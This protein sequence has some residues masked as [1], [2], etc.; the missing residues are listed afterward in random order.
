MG[1]GFANAM[2]IDVE[3]YFQ[4]EAF[5][6]A[7]DRSDWESL[8]SRV[9][10]NTDRLLDI[11]AESGVEATFFVLG[12]VAERYPQLVRDVVA[13]GHELASHGFGQLRVDRQAPD[14]F[15]DDVRRAKRILE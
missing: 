3:D 9:E 7:I 6:S 14:A 1:L 12:W 4:V 8:P 13:Q 2:T 11:L 10:R 15:R 5:A